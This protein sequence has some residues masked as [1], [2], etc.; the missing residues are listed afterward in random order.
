MNIDFNSLDKNSKIWVYQSDRAFSSEEINYLKVKVTSFIDQWQTHGSPI[1][2]GFQILHNQFIILAVDETGPIASGCSIDSS[3]H[4]I[5]TLEKELNVSLL[6]KSIV[7]FEAKSKVLTLHFNQVKEAIQGNKIS[8]SDFYFNNSVTTLDQF[9][10]D[11]KQK[12]EN[13]W[14]AKF[15]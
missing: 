2:G 15:F 11:W 7:A 9:N 3:V 14:A 8:K 4:F 1:N 5:Q 6:D 12:V 13:S 10:K